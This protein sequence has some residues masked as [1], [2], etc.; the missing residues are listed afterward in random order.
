[1]TSTAGVEEG[2]E[3]ILEV[4]VGSTVRVP[5]GIPLINR[6]NGGSPTAVAKISI[7]MPNNTGTT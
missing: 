5:V 1:M 2:I 3:S 7:A 6:V 4:L